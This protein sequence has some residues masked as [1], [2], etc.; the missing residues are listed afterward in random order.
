MNNHIELFVRDVW[1]DILKIED[2]KPDDNFV[3]I[4]GDSISAALCLMRIRARFDV[5]L[6]IEALLSETMTLEQLARAI[7]DNGA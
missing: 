1:S 3:N 7:V 6:P 2:V 4:G 5:D